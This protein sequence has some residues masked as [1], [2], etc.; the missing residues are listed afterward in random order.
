MVDFPGHTRLVAMQGFLEMEA[1]KHR[2]RENESSTLWCL[3]L[4]KSHAK[5]LVDSLHAI[6]KD[7]CIM[8]ALVYYRNMKC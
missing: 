5:H 2:M 1:S 3:S 8:L 6:P 7:D 4:S